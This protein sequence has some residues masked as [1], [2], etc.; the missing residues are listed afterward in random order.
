MKHPELKL[1]RTSPNEWSLTDTNGVGIGSIVYV[2]AADGNPYQTWVLRD[3]A[4]QPVG[5]PLA[6]LAMAARGV[7]EAL[8]PCTRDGCAPMS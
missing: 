6:Q 8:Q 3:G 2:H 7:E 4:Q 5:E 1:R